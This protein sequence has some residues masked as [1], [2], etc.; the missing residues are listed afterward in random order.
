MA[1]PIVSPL[2]LI[3]S[4]LARRAELAKE[5]KEKMW[6]VDFKSSEGR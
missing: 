6:R 3:Q 2:A 1:K 5:R 4:R